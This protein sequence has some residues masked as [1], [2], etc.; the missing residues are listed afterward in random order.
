VSLVYRIHREDCTTTN[1][2]VKE[3]KMVWPVKVEK[4]LKLIF[5]HQLLKLPK[6]KAEVGIQTTS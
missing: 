5:K 3:R 2:K 6:N 4:G 1:T